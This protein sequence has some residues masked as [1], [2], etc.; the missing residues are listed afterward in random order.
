MIESRAVGRFIHLAL[1][2][3][4]SRVDLLGRIAL[5]SRVLGRIAWIMFVISWFGLSGAI[6]VAFFRISGGREKAFNAAGRRFAHF[7]EVIGPT[8]IKL[9]QVLSYRSDL[10]PTEFI[11]PLRRV[12]DQVKRPAGI[13]PRKVLEAAFEASLET[14][15][16]SID[17]SPIAAGSVAVIWRGVSL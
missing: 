1:W 11:A 8:G 12:Q 13:D 9:A 5:L 17:E 2:T 3:V 7:A 16:R 15:F 10:M 4:I 14:L 6:I